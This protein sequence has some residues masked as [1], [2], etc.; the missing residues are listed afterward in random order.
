M[1]QNGVLWL[2]REIRPTVFTWITEN[3]EKCL[4]LN[5][6]GG[7][8]V[9]REIRLKMLL[10]MVLHDLQVKNKNK[11]VQWFVRDLGYSQMCVTH[12]HTYT[13][14]GLTLTPSCPL[15]AGHNKQ[16]CVCMCVTVCVYSLF[17][18]VSLCLTVRVSLCGLMCVCY[19]CVCVCICVWK[20]NLYVTAT[21]FNTCTGDISAWD[22]Y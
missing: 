9:W 2:F 19:L 7:M 21:A 13:Y 6:W 4:H 16:L 11:C 22:Y 17:V 5:E 10:V 20:V 14:P 3:C 12:T 1:I 15:Q 18:C 8:F